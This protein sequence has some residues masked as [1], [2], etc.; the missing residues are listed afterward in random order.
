MYFLKQRWISK[1]KP[2]ILHTNTFTPLHY[3]GYRYDLPEA[4]AEG[5]FGYTFI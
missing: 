4:A 3:L 1:G 2:F 5:E